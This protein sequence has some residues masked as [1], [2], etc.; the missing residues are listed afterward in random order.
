MVHL[1]PTGLGRMEVRVKCLQTI[2]CLIFNLHN[3]VVQLI[4]IRKSKN[5]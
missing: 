3:R 5:V 1:S 2:T 4:G